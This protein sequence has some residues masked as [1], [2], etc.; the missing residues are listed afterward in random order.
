MSSDKVDDEG[1]EEESQESCNISYSVVV[2]YWRHQDNKKKVKVLKH[3]RE[4][5]LV[6]DVLRVKLR[7]LMDIRI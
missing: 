2:T 6:L 4:E 7:Y 3:L 5:F 1:R